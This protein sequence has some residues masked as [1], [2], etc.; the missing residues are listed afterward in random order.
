MSSLISVHA[1]GTDTQPDFPTV[2]I[3]I[4]A[5][6]EADYVS[7]CLEALA[8]QDY[9]PNRVQIILSDNGSTDA[10]AAIAHA[11]G[12]RVLRHPR[13]LVGA[14][15][16]GGALAT[17]SEILAFVDADCVTRTDWLSA[18]VAALATPGVGATGGGYLADPQGT[19]VQRA[20]A[21]T[22]PR[23]T[24]GVAALP[25]GSIVVR[26]ELFLA[27]G[28]FN[29]QLSAG[30]DDDFCRRV[31]DAGLKVVA[32]EASWVIHLGYP[33]TLRAVARR[34]VWHGSYQLDVAETWHEPQLLMTH[35][36]ALGLLAIVISP[37]LGV[38][39]WTVAG[40]LLAPP[41]FLMSVSKAAGRHDQLATVL[42]MIPVAGA[43]YCGRA[44]GLLKNYR[45]LLLSGTTSHERTG[46]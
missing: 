6:N 35:S 5:R 41:V 2:A 27:L 21:L 20:W 16:N 3:V 39:G 22:I 23:A 17:S 42:R 15:R 32:V 4:P 38:A 40:L 13:G 31:R 14:V 30:E 12:V 19:W 28:G 10:T 37:W 9:P 33:R 29:E 43:F 34:Q 46:Q 25:G 26:R 11:H 44:L 1:T 7:Q 45:R 8:R 18:A 24:A 36:F